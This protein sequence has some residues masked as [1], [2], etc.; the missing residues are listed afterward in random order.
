MTKTPLVSIIMNCYNGE[1]YLTESLNSLLKQTYQNWELIFWDNISSDNSKKIFE[2]Y[3]DERFKY[4]LS[5]RHMVLYGARNLAIKKA[6]G[7]FLAFLDTD[8]IW[9]KNKLDLQ[10]KLFLNKNIGLVYANYYKF[11]D[12][13]FF[14]KKIASSKK[15]PFGKVTKQL[16][17]EYPIGMLTVMI[18]KSF[19]SNQTDIFDVSFDMLAD[20][21]FI[22]KF[23]KKYDFACIQ[24]P[25][26]I[27][28][29]H[30]NQLQNK[31]F[32]K[33]IEQ[34]LL[35]YEKIKISKEFGEEK[36]LIMLKNKC[37]FF[38][39]IEN[40]NKKFYLKS[41]KEIIFFP[42]ITGRIKLFLK[43]VLPNVIF[44]K[45]ISLR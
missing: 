29:Q 24:E 33:Q 3:K 28:R 15:L 17:N 25:L 32:E 12:K 45:I 16:L 26:A 7:E 22:L 2:K 19:I 9:L 36:N 11:N 39:I 35:W 34:M 14:K 40:I 31:N 30:E 41:F 43:L 4:F 27:Y 42:S 1:K 5:D 38:Q 13:N 20:M 23:S 6:K 37:K 10:V 21:D 8:D 18:R 44:D